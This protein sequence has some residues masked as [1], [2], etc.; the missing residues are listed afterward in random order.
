MNQSKNDGEI[1][2]LTT[3]EHGRYKTLKRTVDNE[4]GAFLR[5]GEALKEIRD[6]KLY[7]GDYK[8]WSEFCRATF[9]LSRPHA[10]RLIRGHEA[11]KKMAPI[12]A[13]NLLPTNEGQVRELLKLESDDDRQAVWE[14]V[15]T[16]ADAT[17]SGPITA[18]VISKKVTEWRK[19]S[20]EPAANNEI[21]ADFVEV[22]SEKQQKA[23]TIDSP[24]DVETDAEQAN[25]ESIDE[26]SSLDNGV[27]RCPAVLLN[28]EEVP[29]ALW[30][31]G[32]LDAECV[33][34][35]LDK[36]KDTPRQVETADEACQLM[37]L[38]LQGAINGIMEADNTRERRNACF[39]VVREVL[40]DAMVVASRTG[41][42]QSTGT[43]ARKV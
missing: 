3:E 35:K 6:R 39:H 31:N 30:E 32:Y 38:A 27:E 19:R 13:K 36:V 20:Q 25:T 18:K 14:E 9:L 4:M 40:R 33:Q 42:L 10:D 8:R 28:G 24:A 34:T 11:V 23:T 26:V 22:P 5:V 29:D 37:L 41:D 12:G 17:S 1:A 7:R 2:P 21:R 15:V 43:E 16:V